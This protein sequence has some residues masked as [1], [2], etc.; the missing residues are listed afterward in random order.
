MPSKRTIPRICRHCGSAFIAHAQQVRLGLGFYC[1]RHCSG[2]SSAIRNGLALS[3]TDRFF[4]YVLQNETTECW[5]WSGDITTRGYGLFR[6]NGE[7]VAAHQSAWEQVAGLIPDNFVVCHTCDVR[8]CVRNDDAGIYVVDGIVYQ[9]RGHLWIGTQI[10][11][12]ADMILKGRSPYG[13]TGN[14]VILERHREE[15]GLVTL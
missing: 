3:L 6:Y 11:N 5:L 7:R 9:R 15:H 8:R 14:T 1:S 13:D 10:A 12:L 4:S 2:A